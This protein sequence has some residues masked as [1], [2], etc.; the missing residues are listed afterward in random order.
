MEFTFGTENVFQAESKGQYEMSSE[1]LTLT[2]LSGLP[3]AGKTTLALDIIYET[4]AV[5]VSRDE[6][7]QALKS[8]KN[9]DHL[10]LVMF[11]VAEIVL[12]QNH[13]VVIDSWNLKL[14]DAQMWQELS[15]KTHARL[16]WIH[17]PTSIE[18]CERRDF[19]RN[20]KSEPLDIREIARKYA[21]RLNELSEGLSYA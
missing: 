18:E 5:L 9:E 20:P 11:E 2:V 15:E 21:E 17:V 4:K 7:R 13:S 1:T 3:G 6:L 14:S 12:N 19:Y 10:S 16:N 8:L